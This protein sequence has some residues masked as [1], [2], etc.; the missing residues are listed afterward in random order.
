MQS[1]PFAANLTFI[2]ILI[3]FVAFIIHL[4]GLHETIFGSRE[5]KARKEDEAIKTAIAQDAA[6]VQATIPPLEPGALFTAKITPL[7]NNTIQFAIK[8]S[9]EARNIIVQQNLFPVRILTYPNLEYE[10]EKQ[11]YDRDMERLRRSP[12]LRDHIEANSTPEPEKNIDITIEY[13]AHPCGMTRSFRSASEAKAWTEQL[14]NGL[15]IF[16]RELEANETPAEASTF[17]AMR[18]K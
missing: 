2:L 7:P 18:K 5:A 15:E 11:Q 12:K 8:L 3:F 17:I 1:L 14:R 13:F 6:R 4:T 9:P 10:E 16:Q